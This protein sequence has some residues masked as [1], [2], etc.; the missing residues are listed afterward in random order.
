MPTF[1][2]LSHYQCS[3]LGKATAQSSYSEGSGQNRRR[4]LA[5]WK[6]PFDSFGMSSGS[7]LVVFPAKN[8]R[9]KWTD[10]NTPS[11]YIYISIHLYIYISIYMYIYNI[12]SINEVFM[13]L[14]RLHHIYI[15]GVD[16]TITALG[17]RPLPTH[18]LW[19]WSWLLTLVTQAL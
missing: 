6:E 10:Q 14:Y 16:L 1:V 8:G 19:P 15:E 9:Q 4:Y 2:W 13:K 11:I 7:L 18:H 12:E 17:Q 3:P 5:W